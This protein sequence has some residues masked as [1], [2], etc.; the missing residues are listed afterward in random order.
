MTRTSLISLTLLA[1]TPAPAA[2]DPQGDFDFAMMHYKRATEGFQ[3]YWSLSLDDTRTLDGCDQAIATAQAGGVT[4]TAEHKAACDEYRRYHLLAQAE[5]AVSPA[6]EFLFFLSYVDK[7]SNHEENG[8]AMAKAAATCSAEIDRLLAAGMPTDIKVRIGNAEH[9]EIPMSEAKA[10]VCEPLAKAA[11]TWAKDVGAARTE[12]SDKI[13]KPY[14]AVGITGDRLELLVDHIDY[15]MYGVGG[16]QLR[17]PQQLK[18][19][20]VIFELLGPNTET[21]RYTLRRYQFKGN[22]LVS[23][24]SADYR[25][26]PAA[27]AYR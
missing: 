20:A 3:H 22:T 17:T 6:K 21:G 13:A 7:A 9:F 19:A 12:R 14:K 1:L 24:T 25:R 23:T 5:K 8:P 2:A 10:K 4:T 26:R 11:K 15:A 16:G 27:S 18:G